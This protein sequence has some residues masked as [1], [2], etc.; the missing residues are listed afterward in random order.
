MAKCQVCGRRT[1]GRIC[2][3]CQEAGSNPDGVIARAREMG[4]EVLWSPVNQ[5]YVI[6]EKPGDDSQP[7]LVGVKNTIQDVKAFLEREEDA[8]NEPE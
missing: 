4:F 3:P 7:E 5:G 2:G 6:L 1:F 8:R